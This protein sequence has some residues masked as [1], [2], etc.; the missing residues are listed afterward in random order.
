M[1]IVAEI[2]QAVRTIPDFPKPGIQFKDITPILSDP[3]LLHQAVDALAEPFLDEEITKVVWDNYASLS[4][5]T[6]GRL[7]LTTG[8]VV[9]VRLDSAGETAGTV[10][11]PVLVQPGQ[12]DQVIAI[13][14]DST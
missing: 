2:E 9:R 7:G 11:L 8:D 12:H 4:E 1:D 10:E 3:V 13:A 6:A 14:V 5:T